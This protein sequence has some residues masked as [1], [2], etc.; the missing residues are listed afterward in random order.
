MRDATSVPLFIPAPARCTDNAAMIG[1]AGGGV[2]RGDAN[3]E[4][5]CAGGTRLLRNGERV[6][7]QPGMR[8]V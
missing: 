3:G 8:L 4:G 7:I 6:E 5:D 2:A 1:L